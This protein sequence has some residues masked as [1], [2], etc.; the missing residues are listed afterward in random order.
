MA[1]RQWVIVMAVSVMSLGTQL[2]CDA[3]VIPSETFDFQNGVDGYS[4]GVDTTIDD[5]TRNSPTAV[6]RLRVRYFNPQPWH[7]EVH[8]VLIRFEGLDSL[9]GI[10]VDAATLTLTFQEEHVAWEEAVIDVYPVIRS[11]VD[12]P[13]TN[14]TM[15]N[16]AENWDVLGAQGDPNDRGMLA[17][18]IA[19]GPRQFFDIQYADDSQFDFALSPSLV[20]S[21]IAQP[22]QN[23]G[24]I[25]V[26]NPDSKSD[27][28]FS[29]NDDETVAFRPILTIASA[30]V[31]S[32]IGVMDLN[33]DHFMNYSDFAILENE[34]LNTYF[35]YDLTVM[36]EDWLVPWNP[37]LSDG[38]L[39][40]YFDFQIL[41]S[42]WQVCYGIE[43]LA[44]LAENWLTCSD[45]TTPPDCIPGE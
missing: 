30:T 43:H 27:V 8:S 41:S 2:C 12:D 11:W 34:W 7:D 13:N 33:G 36:V 19:M 25:L 22:D 38:V 3:E 42:G 20:Q 23:F 18:S 16:V 9:N 39:I 6:D 5:P 45:G 32:G 44:E 15:A 14:W 4:G 37:N 40:D 31:C 35:P 17:G 26:M 1:L 24:V 28:T 21:W 10:V 29:S